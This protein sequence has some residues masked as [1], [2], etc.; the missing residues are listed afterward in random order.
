MY[1]HVCIEYTKML[2]TG[3]DLHHFVNSKLKPKQKKG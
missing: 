1:E 2:F 3:N